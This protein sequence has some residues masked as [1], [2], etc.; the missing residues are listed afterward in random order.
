MHREKG[1]AKVATL[2]KN[3]EFVQ[4]DIDNK[5]SLEAALSGEASHES[6]HL[7][8]FSFVSMSSMHDT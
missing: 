3:S 4:V 1:A 2:G 5:D 6:W 8:I 7:F